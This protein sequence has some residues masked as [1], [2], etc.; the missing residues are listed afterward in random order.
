MT[1]EIAKGS[2]ATV[3]CMLL[4]SVLYVDDPTRQDRDEAHV[5][6]LLAD[7]RRRR[8]DRPDEN[9]IQTPLRVVRRGDRYKIIAGSYRWLAALRV[10]LAEVPC[11]VLPPDLDEAGE[12]IEQFVD[13]NLHK[14]YAP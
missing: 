3:V 13:N 5:A 7:Y 6:E 8:K 2:S 10:P 4:T 9:P 14:P 11:I 12:E 1:A